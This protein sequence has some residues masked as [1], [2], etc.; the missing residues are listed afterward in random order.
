MLTGVLQPAPF[1][2]HEWGALWEEFDFYQIAPPLAWTMQACTGRLARSWG[3]L[4]AMDGQLD[5]PFG[6]A[7]PTVFVANYRNHRIQVFAL[8]TGVCP[9]RFVRGLGVQAFQFP[10]AAALSPNGDMTDCGN[11]RVQVF[12]QDGTFVWGVGH[13][14]DRRWAVTIAKRDRGGPQWRGV[15]DRLDTKQIARVYC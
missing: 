10:L 11:H 1:A 5:Y 12:Q 9:G 14:G 2:P 6:I 3:P 4:G 15:G 13:I 8:E 7:V